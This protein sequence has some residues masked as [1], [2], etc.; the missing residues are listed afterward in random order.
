MDD[1]RLH[2]CVRAGLALYCPGGKGKLITYSPSRIMIKMIFLDSL[3]ISKLFVFKIK[4]QFCFCSRHNDTVDSFCLDFKKTQFAIWKY[5]IDYKWYLRYVINKLITPSLKFSPEHSTCKRRGTL[6]KEG[7]SH[8]KNEFFDNYISPELKTQMVV[9]ISR[10]ESEKGLSVS[11]LI[12][13]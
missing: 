2:K 3:Y 13:T 12:Y 4:I 7:K 9:K 1:L 10:G 5:V 8:L 11:L 6:F